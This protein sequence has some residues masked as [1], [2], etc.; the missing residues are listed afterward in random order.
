MKGAEDAGTYSLAYTFTNI[1]ATI[2]A[3]GMGNYQ[4]SDVT[5][6]YTDGTYIAARVCTSAAALVCFVTALFFTGFSRATLVCCAFLMLYRL[7]EG[8]SGVY[9]CVLQKFG[10]YKMISVSYCIKGGLTFLTFCAALHF[11]EL[12]QA[13]L[14]ML[15]AFLPVFLLFDI[16]R[17]VR[18]AGFA[19]KVLKRDIVNVLFP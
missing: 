7:L 11:F 10:D 2:A 18:R 13:I 5:G 14:A 9:L 4:I 3:F 8:L 12:P 17:A 16:P 15:A 1:F 6:R 19:A